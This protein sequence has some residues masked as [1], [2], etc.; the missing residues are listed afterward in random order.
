MSERS[1]QALSRDAP[2]TEQ[3]KIADDGLFRKIS[4]GKKTIPI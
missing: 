3:E 2:M 4:R 1:I